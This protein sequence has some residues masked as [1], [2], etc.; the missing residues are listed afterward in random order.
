M[1]QKLKKAMLYEKKEDNKV[2]C[3]LC[4]HR[5]LIPEGK[6]GIC[7]VRENREGTLYSLNYGK[8][9][10]KAIDPIEKKPLF[11]FLPGTKAY[12]VATVGCNFRCLHC[13]NYSISQYPREHS[14]R[15]IGEY[16]S[17]EEIVDD[18]INRGCDTIA[19]TYV[20]PTVFFE[21][22]YEVAKLCQKQGIKNVFV[23][24]GFMTAEA[25]KTIQ[26]Y[27]E[28]ANVDLKSYR[29]EF[30]T[31]IEGGKLQPVLDNIKLMHELGIWVEVTTLVIPDYNDSDRE[32]ESI[33]QFIKSVDPAIPWHVSRFQPAYRM[34]DIPPTPLK[35][36]KKAM[37]IGKKVGLRY[38]YQGNTPG[39]GENTFCYNC[40]KVLIERYGFSLS[41]NL[42]QDGKCP[43]C[44]SQIDG[45]FKKF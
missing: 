35:T 6:R 5:C 16:F 19:H 14:G 11:H 26:P 25:L 37:D 8:L 32:L 42:I 41:N 28:G 13:Q 4:N 39:K 21:Y 40:G 9:V 2:R 3:N 30:Y 17:P 33:A 31:E 1:S 29:D 45:V 23:T 27:L 7:Q 10:S 24:N 15:I 18:A 38:V 36:L 44:G 22:A 43:K 34:T 20:E 12:S